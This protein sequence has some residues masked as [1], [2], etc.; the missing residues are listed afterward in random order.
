M[1]E[2]KENPLLGSGFD[3]M[4]TFENWKVAF[5]TAAP[6]YE[7]LQ[8]FKRHLLTDEAFVLTQGQ[9]TI[10][11]ISDDNKTLEE[12]VMLP[13]CVYV[14]K[15]ATWHHVQV[16]K[17]ALLVVIENSNTTKENTEQITLEEWKNSKET[18]I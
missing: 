7:A 2:I 6:Q 8:V 15:K 1:I 4:H 17:D 10:Y 16:S 5:I 12:T 11:T 18:T 3:A 9:A 14:V 13:Q